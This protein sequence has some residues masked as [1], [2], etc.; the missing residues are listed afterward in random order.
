[1]TER[2]RGILRP[3]FSDAEVTRLKTLHGLTDAQIT[4]LKHYLSSALDRLCGAKREGVVNE[5]RLFAD[6]IAQAQKIS[7]RWRQAMAHSAGSEASGQLSLAA[8]AIDIDPEALANGTLP[9]FIRPADLL[10]VIHSAAQR[11]LNDFS[12]KAR[13]R[14][15]HPVSVEV[16]V[17]IDARLKEPGDDD[18]VAAWKRLSRAAVNTSKEERP[19]LRGIADVV[20]EAV[21]REWHRAN[22]SKP[23]AV[24]PT[25]EASMRAFVRARGRSSSGSRAPGAG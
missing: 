21:Y 5:L 16:I 7:E 18:S 19:S 10:D 15:H 17:E 12:T 13:R 6:H 24:A 23:G 2:R 20:W 8:S 1:M 25:A 4:R 9:P 3:T 11:A 22:K 14:S